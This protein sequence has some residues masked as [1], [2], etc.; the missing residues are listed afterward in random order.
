MKM[1]KILLC[2]ILA[3][4]W[5]STVAQA[6]EPYCFLELADDVEQRSDSVVIVIGVDM[7]DLATCDIFQ[8]TIDI[9]YGAE[10]AANES[11]MRLVEYPDRYLEQAG[12]HRADVSF[13]TFTPYRKDVR[14]LLFIFDHTMDARVNGR[15]RFNLGRYP[16]ARLTLDCSMLGD[17]DKYRVRVM[18]GNTNTVFAI[19][20]GRETSDPVD[21]VILRLRV[22]NRHVTQVSP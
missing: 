15:G 11:G 3:A 20:K 1:N 9:P 14:R 21:E 6:R 17:G 4:T 18:P 19:G 2:I 13:N 5:L 12:K 10:Y 7:G 16:L 8:A 22:S